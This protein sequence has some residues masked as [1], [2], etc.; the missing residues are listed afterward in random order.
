MT[1]AL[2]RAIERL[3]RLT[4][5]AASGLPNWRVLTWFPLLALLGTV[6]L[7]ALQLS[8]TSS[9]AHWPA[10]GSG[11]DPRLLFGVPRPIR[12]DEWLVAQSWL[13][14]QVENG[15]PAI[16]P[17]FP[18]GMDVTVLN[19]LPSADWSTLFR[20]HLWGYLLFGLDAGMAWQWWVPAF[21]LVSGCYLLVVSL[22][23]RRP[24]TAA[25]LAV[26]VWFVPL[27]QWWYGPST[28]WPI[29]FAFIA[30]AATIWLLVD[31][32]R[33]V[34]VTWSVVM[35]YCAVTMGMGMYVPFILPCV[36]LLVAF[37]VGFLLR[38]RPWL[39]GGAR[40]TL[41][42][43][44]P[45]LAAAAAAG[46]VLL[47]W[48]LSRQDTFE[49]IFS[50]VYP[51]ARSRPV[52]TLIAEDP[53]LTGIGGAPWA[54]ALKGVDGR[55]LGENASEASGVFLLA[56]FVV[57][58][59]IWFIV[60]S[61]RKRE[62]VDPVLV[63][64]L[65]ALLI[66]VAVLL[67]PSWDAVARLLLLHL[68]TAERIRIFF[69]VALPLFAA[70]IVERVDHEPV[71]RNWIPGLIAA[72]TAAGFIGFLAWE[73]AV[74][75]PVILTVAANWPVVAALLVVAILLLFVRRASGFAALALLIATVLTTGT[76][77]PV[78]RGVFDLRETEIGQAIERIDDEHPGAWVGVGS[79]ETY[80]LLVEN[81]V[82]SYSGVQTYPS[83]EM[84]E[85][86]DPASRFEN[87][88]N[89]L[90]HVLWHFGPGEPTPRNPRPDVIQV[91]LDACSDFAQEHVTY[92]LTDAAQ[93][94]TGCLEERFEVQQGTIVLTVFEVVP[95]PAL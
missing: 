62:R 20:P 1:S 95:E 38:R 76:V 77:N 94:A 7:I 67:I 63:A 51:G 58:G 21:A 69:V 79:F 83:E 52:G 37:A 5:P 73:I 48:V 75:D 45:F 53:Y 39:D 86:I 18:G 13:V 46:A 41:R 26:S 14:S 64:V 43:L 47:T 91:N 89:R 3:H 23:P 35:G 44:A 65:V 28:M 9:G 19:E 22:L 81:G 8:G 32:R 25:M 12:S 30:M 56:L 6:A 55:L 54:D 92:V 10:L 50:T 15:F 31:R 60:R 70:L 40:E 66:M 57:P 80:A 85:Q 29:A 78:Y 2:S 4:E 17:T 93:T 27:V 82:E 49:A 59:L 11:A 36:I 87:R 33:W 84:W 74:N 34:I 88:W 42:R 16:N 90:G 68:T 71:E 61:L 24:L 72:G